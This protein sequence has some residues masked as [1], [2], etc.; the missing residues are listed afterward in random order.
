MAAATFEFEHIFTIVFIALAL[1]MDA[2]SLGFG[3]GMKGIRLLDILKISTIVGLFHLLMPLVGIAMGTYA[4]MLLGDIAVIAGGLLL[5]ALGIHMIYQAM[6]GDG[7]VF[8]DYRTT[9]GLLAFAMSVSV[10]SFSVGVSLGLFS[11]H[12]AFVVLLFGMTGGIMSV[13]G[14]MLGRKLSSWLGIY[15]EAVGGIILFMFGIK[16]VV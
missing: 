16:F 5:I 8:M 12:I 4:S 15:G 11:T 3:I 10:D 7:V 14:L 6:W 2:F 13:L 9:W 1:G